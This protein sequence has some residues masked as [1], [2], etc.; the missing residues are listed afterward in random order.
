MTASARNNVQ[1]LGPETGP[2]LMFAHG[3]GTDQNMWG[4][5]LPY[6]A[7]KYRVVLFDHVG[8]GGSDAAA[9][10]SEKYSSL[11]P[12]VADLLDICAE[13]DLR[14]VTLVGHSVGSMMAVAAA[15]QEAARGGSDGGPRLKRLVLLTASPSYLDYPEDGYTGGFTQE[16]LDELFESLDANYLVWASSMA[17]V[18]MNHPESADLGAEITGSFGRITPGVG[19]D[20][21][22]VAFLSDVRHLLADVVL[23][24]LILQTTD[25]VVTPPH[26]G[27]Y[28][29]ERLP[30]GTLETLGAKGHFPQASA[31]EETAAAILGYLKDQ[32]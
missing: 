11:D 24:V 6:F 20:F 26:I 17:P 21:A 12:Y 9:Y 10:N 28:L 4:R 27:D 3:F 2:V 22:R 7:D 8:S 30:N 14:D 29:L 19:R 25:D 31:P 16:E 32:P 15:A 23:P 1:I 13:L 18:F 5:V